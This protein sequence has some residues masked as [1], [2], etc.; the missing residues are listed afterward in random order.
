M[1]LSTI[2]YLFLKVVYICYVIFE[3]YIFIIVF[4]SLM[5]INNK[6]NYKIITHVPRETWIHQQFLFIFKSYLYFFVIFELYS[7]IIIFLLLMI[8]N[9]KFNYKKT[10]NVSR[11]TLVINKIKYYYFI[12]YFFK[13]L[14]FHVEHEIFKFF[15]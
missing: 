1:K 7:F 13:N 6:F 15:V 10:I 14:M 9:N 3:L 12:L 8:I 11:G 5:I 2:F 4:Y